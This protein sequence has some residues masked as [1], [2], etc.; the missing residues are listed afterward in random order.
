MKSAA[1]SDVGQLHLA[2]AL[3]PERGPREVIRLATR[4]GKHACQL[5]NRRTITS[6]LLPTTGLLLAKHHGFAHQLGSPLQQSADGV[7]VGSPT[8]VCVQSYSKP[9]LVFLDND[10]GGAPA[11][12]DDFAAR[13]AAVIVIRLDQRNVI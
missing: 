8:T 10:G 11:G 5:R 7:D 2:G 9:L 12:E 1:E 13:K 3:G 4:N 6:I